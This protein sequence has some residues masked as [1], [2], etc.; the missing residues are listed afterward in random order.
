M[1]FFKVRIPIGPP[2][3]GNLTG[4]IL[5]DGCSTERFDFFA[6][7]GLAATRAP[8]SGSSDLV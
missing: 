5:I 1:R 2:V 8:E 4:N 7:W 3:T 6:Q